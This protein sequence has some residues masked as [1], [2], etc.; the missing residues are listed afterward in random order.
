MR[1]PTGSN[2][3]FCFTSWSNDF[4]SELAYM[5]CLPKPIFQ[6]TLSHPHPKPLE[7]LDRIDNDKNQNKKAKLIKNKT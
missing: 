7:V 2:T 6:E 4:E 1:M 3:L 5:K